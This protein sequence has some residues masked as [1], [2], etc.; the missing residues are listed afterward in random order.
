MANKPVPYLCGGIFFTLL[1]EAKGKPSSRRKLKTGIRDK[2]TYKNMLESLIQIFVPSFSQPAAGRTFEG[3]TS[4]YR[5]CKVSWGIN[6][7]FDDDVEIRNF[8]ERV[9]NSYSSAL[10]PMDDFIDCYLNTGSDERMR[11]LIQALLTLIETDKLI[12]PDALFY[13]SDTPVTKKELLRQDHYFLSSLLLGIW[14]Y[15]VTNRPD[16]EAGRPTFE[17]LHDRADQPNAKWKFKKKFAMNYPR[18]FS[19]DLFGKDA[20]AGNK[21]EETGKPDT[22]EEEPAGEENTQ[23]PVIEVYE[24]PFTDPVTQKQVVAQFHV[25]ARDNGIAIGQHFGD[26][27]IGRRGRKDE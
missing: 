18:H 13:L 22:K 2:I 5:A 21:D 9:K 4:D 24:A 26:L 3:D 19:F 16:N 27:Y 14:H 7:P 8:D 17:A 15:I 11:W 10:K 23:E 20:P 25:E 6:L 1:T 12:T